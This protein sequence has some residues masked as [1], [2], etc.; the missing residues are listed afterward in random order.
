MPF[1][2]GLI[3][4]SVEFRPLGNRLEVG[5]NSLSE[6]LRDTRR[7]FKVVFIC[8]GNRARSAL[9]QSYFGRGTEGL[10]VKVES[11]GTL[12][13]EPGPALPEAVTA[14][15][16]LGLDLSGHQSRCL[17]G[18]DFSAADL[19]VGFEQAH[20]ANAVVEAR[21]DATKTFKL[22]ELARLLREVPV[23]TS[24]TPE[25]RAR[26][27]IE[28]SHAIRAG[29]RFVPGE[30]LADPIGKGDRVFRETARAIATLCDEVIGALFGPI[31]S[32]SQMGE[33]SMPPL[34]W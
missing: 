14:G 22:P 34:E 28:D 32:G 20:V 24:S 1:I 18:L 3:D 2:Q 6:R 30:E 4:S 8:T 16:E 19:V 11:A 26:R 31:A 21:A 7:M 29:G 13:L 12:D 9:A 17:V 15:S 27:A 25:D 33:R 5:V 10:D 23:F